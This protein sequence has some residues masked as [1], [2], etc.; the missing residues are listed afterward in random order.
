M[1]HEPT[2][3][4]DADHCYSHH[5]DEPIQGGSYYRICGECFHLYPTVDDLRAA[6]VAEATKIDPAVAKVSP[7]VE[8]IVFCPLCTHDW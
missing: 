1:P 3:A 6:Y 7:P 2:E 4:C 5:E 8:K